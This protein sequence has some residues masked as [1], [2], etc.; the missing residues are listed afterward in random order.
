MRIAP[1]PVI[2]PF[3]CWNWCDRRRGARGGCFPGLI[4]RLPIRHLSGPGPRSGGAGA[5]FCG[6]VMRFDIRHNLRD[7]ERGLSDIGQKQLP[8]ATALALNDTAKDIL[9]ALRNHM[10]RVFDNPTRWTL[11]AFHFRRATKSKPIATIE[12][13]Q[14][15]RG[16]HYLEV[17][18]VG[19]GRP[20]TGWEKQI[21]QKLGLDA[22]YMA[23]TNRLKRDRHGNIPRGN[24]QRVLS[25]IGASSLSGTNS[26]R[27]SKRRAKGVGNYFVGGPRNNLRPGVYERTDAGIH[28]VLAF[29]TKTP[30]Y[31]KLFDFD[32]VVKAEADRVLETHL[33]RR[34]AE[35]IRTARH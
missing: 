1:P 14:A 15:I 25:R 2:Y 4:P 29:N 11:N 20:H 23:A 13:K 28:R 12:R 19:G 34:L 16:K 7:L 24:M 30:S 35:A 31:R 21:G 3:T 6:D 26:T 18:A 17:Q 5:S 27:D 8:F 9:T 32:G 10:G 33:A 22:G